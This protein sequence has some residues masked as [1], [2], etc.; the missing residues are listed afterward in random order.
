M[1]TGTSQSRSLQHAMC[2]IRHK[3]NFLDIYYTHYHNPTNMLRGKTCSNS[4]KIASVE[5]LY[6]IQYA[7]IKSL[8]RRLLH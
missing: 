7:D 6:P 2:H 5:Q 3:D 8:T 1:Y 4:F